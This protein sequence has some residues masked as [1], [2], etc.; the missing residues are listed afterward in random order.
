M[1]NFTQQ[2]APEAAT[3]NLRFFFITA[4]SFISGKEIVTLQVARILRQAGCR[5]FFMLNN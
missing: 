5:I 1:K 3:T 2:Q 4:S